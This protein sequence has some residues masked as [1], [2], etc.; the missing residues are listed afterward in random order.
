MKSSSDLFGQ[1][2]IKQSDQK[3]T[4]S[5]SLLFYLLVLH[6]RAMIVERKNEAISW[7]VLMIGLKLEKAGSDA[8]NCHD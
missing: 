7:G 6:D 5:S 3:A 4:G 8:I 2:S 1:N